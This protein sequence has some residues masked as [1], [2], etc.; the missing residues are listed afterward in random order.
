MAT[1]AELREILNSDWV[2]DKERASITY[3]Q[4]R[5]LLCVVDAL[6]SHERFEFWVSSVDCECPLCGG[7][8]AKHEPT[9]AWLLARKLNGAQ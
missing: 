2:D 3:G 5:D 4:L 1:L 7:E 9:C 8:D 6:A